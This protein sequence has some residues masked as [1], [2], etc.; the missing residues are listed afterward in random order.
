VIYFNSSVLPD[1]RFGWDRPFLATLTDLIMLNITLGELET[2]SGGIVLS[3]SRSVSLAGISIDSRTLKPGD[4]FFAI[5]GPANDGHRFIA[6]ALGRGA[7]GVVVDSQDPTPANFPSDRILLQV[8]NTHQALKDL[9]S[10]I[11]RLWR[12][13]LVAITGSMGK[14]T[15]K[16]FAT[17][18]LQTE[19]TVYRS[20]G[21]YNNLFGLPLALLGLSPDDRI[22][23]FEM[24]MSEPG[25]IAQMCAIARPDV[26]IITNVAPVHL[27]FFDSIEGI[28]RAKGELAEGLSPTGTLIY[29]ADDPLVSR[30]ASRYGGNRISFGES[31]HADVR[32][33]GIEIVG[34]RE[35]RFRLTCV[36]HVRRCLIPL[37]GRH[38]VM[39][40]LPA[41]ALG[42]YFRMDLERIAYALSHLRQPSM[43]GQILRF[44]GP[45]TVID[46]SYNSNPRALMEMIAAVSPATCTRRIL[47]AGEMLELGHESPVLHYQCGACAAEH[48]FDIIVAVQGAA[49]E[50]ARGALAGGV[51]GSQVHFFTEVNPAIDFVSRKVQPGDLVL[52][53]GSRGVHLEKMVQALRSHY[54]EEIL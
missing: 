5:R 18:L 37:S 33:D 10:E 47:V 15:T 32:A 16:E 39:N 20:P 11:R 36:G 48:G 19:Y 25:E 26:G 9:A 41:V 14:T 34:L 2:I 4:L 50:L 17:S 23:I 43:R 3:G 54:P 38:Y 28:A 30:I 35:T 24:G 29:N 21:N 8:D 7:M 51:P 22:G 45:I 49:Q 52:I 6:D 27:A 13:S 53:K 31:E 46:D 1:W 12:G 44:A 40:A 42:C